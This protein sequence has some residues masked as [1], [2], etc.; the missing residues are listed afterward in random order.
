MSLT[1]INAECKDE[2]EGERWVS[3]LDPVRF[4]ILAVFVYFSI[5][6]VWIFLS[7]IS[8]LTNVN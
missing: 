2:G 3:E 4:V 5:F 6:F 7:F 8:S 1:L